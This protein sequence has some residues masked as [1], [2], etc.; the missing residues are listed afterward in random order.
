M[1]NNN[2]FNTE[3]FM[4]EF[5]FAVKNTFKNRIVFIG[6][7]GSRSRNE[8][9][10]NS[11]I[12]TVVILDKLS[13][14]DLISYKASIKNLP[15]RDKICGF[16]SGK[17]ELVNWEKSELFQFYYDTVPYFGNLDFIKKLITIEDIKH[18]I[19]TGACSIYHACCHNTLHENSNDI[20]KELL[21]T[22]VI[23]IQASVFLRTGKYVK[24]KKE[25]LNYAKD[26]EK[27]IINYYL[28]SR[29][30]KEK[31]LNFDIVSKALFDFSKNIIN[32]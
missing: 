18:S 1:E 26:E 17:N 27:E 7:Q 28:I 8:E 15:H 29:D 21:K 22:A 5:I 24:Y 20:L 16:I 2:I 25:L 3:N 11:D 14:D 9:T 10:Q 6:L 4:T 13:F 30:T 31:T 32:I 19:K 23:T 12:D